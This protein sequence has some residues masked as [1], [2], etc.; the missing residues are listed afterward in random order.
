MNSY[1]NPNE[2][3]QHDCEEGMDKHVF[4]IYYGCTTFVIAFIIFM[5]LALVGCTTTEM[6]PVPEVHEYYHHTADTLR[7]TDS[8]YHYE[9]TIIRE[10]D[11]AQMAAYGI[12]M[13]AMQKAFLIQNDRLKQEVSRLMEHHVDTMIVHDSVPVTVPIYI[14][15]Q[16]AWENVTSHLRD[17]ILLLIFISLALWIWRTK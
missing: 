8:T 13:N 3:W 9:T 4:S 1:H 10:L 15:R 17:V 2:Y 7:Q 5:A 6:V 16:S 11:S 14:K 12:Q